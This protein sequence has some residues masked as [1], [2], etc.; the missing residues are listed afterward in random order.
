MALA[1]SVLKRLPLTA[2]MFYL[3]VGVGVGPA[4]LEL[5]RL[6]PLEHAALLERLTEVAVIVSLFSAGLK[7]RSPLTDRRW[8]LPVRLA[9]I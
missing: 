8:L 6:D 2:A 5:I 1:G 7:L 3:A 9:T 4:G